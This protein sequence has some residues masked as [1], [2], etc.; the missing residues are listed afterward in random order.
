MKQL[1][2]RKLFIIMLAHCALILLT[3]SAQAATYTV[4]TTADSGAGSLR[5]AVA[6]ANS[7]PDDDTINFSIPAGDP[8]CTAGGIC[9][10]TLRTG[11]LVVNA[12]SA[13]GK[14]SIINATGASKLLLDGNKNKTD[15]NEQW[16][17]IFYVANGADLTVD[18]VT[19]TNGRGFGL[20]NNSFFGYGGGIIVDGGKLTLLNS[21]VIG[22]QANSTGGAGF[23]GGIY[24]SGTL[25][26]TNSSLNNN[27]LGNGGGI[28]NAA[29]G[30]ATITNSTLNGNFTNS[31][32][33]NGGGIFN[34]GSLTVSN[35]TISNNTA[36]LA[37]SGIYNNG[38]AT[39]TL[40]TINANNGLANAGIY[41]E[42]NG[43][44]TVE[45][46]TVSNNTSRGIQNN[47]VF[48]LTNSTVK[49]NSTTTSGA[50]IS[51]NGSFEIK[52][53]TISGNM[54]RNNGGGL[55]N[56]GTITIT[57]AT[58]TNNGSSANP[59]ITT[60]GG[61]IFN[62]A[63]ATAN[64]FNTIVARNISG[65]QSG[66]PDFNGAVSPSSSYNIIGNNQMTTGI[67]DGVNGN[68][69]GTPSSPI[70]PR[71]APL[72]NYGGATQTHALFSDS[73][74]IDKGKSFGLT[75][76]QPGFT[77]PVDS[78][79]VTNAPG[80]DGADIGSFEVQAS[81]PVSLSGLV[82]YGT[83]PAQ[84]V[85]YV[86]GALLTANGPFLAVTDTNSSGYYAFETNLQ[87]DEQYTVIPSKT[88]RVNG[89]TSFDATLVLRCV[90]AGNNCDLTPNQKIAAD[91]DGN[92]SVQAFDA[93]LILRFVAANGQNSETGQVGNWKFVDSSKT[94]NPL[95]ASQSNQNYTAF[96]IGEIDGDWTP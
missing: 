82:I 76:D 8:N 72:G 33:A 93:T 15:I 87:K 41:N 53:S 88:D 63:S 43:T 39:I 3:F 27:Y 35:S 56:N 68:Q 24:N 19:I 22:N 58:I 14:L 40:S 75:T 62:T 69:V 71:L 12:A 70:N 91:A 17:R 66:A 38:S 77:R 30:T 11:E 46:S 96:L 31:G 59:N 83:S 74:A 57:S 48:T 52:N 80:G 13:S 64:L 1:R 94:Y 6:T 4:T 89:I 81:T 20:T 16:S 79:A 26:V 10:I 86:S 61:G 18:G 45:F 95:S 9:T 23:G 32:N 90:A 85:K 36:D 2:R 42:S 78:S 65:S 92:N 5:D 44:I 28:F 37:G 49:G 73:P 47:G 50:G 21:I 7:T 25:I 84:Q 67:T 54:A 55:Y 29:N 60:G 51:N 34:N